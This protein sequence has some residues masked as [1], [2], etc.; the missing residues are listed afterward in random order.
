MISSQAKSPA[1]AF[2]LLRACG[3]AWAVDSA[4]RLSH[5]LP[6]GRN[7]ARVSELFRVRGVPLFFPC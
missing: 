1:L 2:V 7:A 4:R 6:Q 3:L 5:E